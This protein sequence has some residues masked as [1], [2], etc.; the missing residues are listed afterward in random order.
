MAGLKSVYER[1][2]E[3]LETLGHQLSFYLKA[4]AWTPRTIR[5]YKKEIFRIL[6]EVALG[7]GSLAL[8]GGTSP[9]SAA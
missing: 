7:T 9:S 6:A 2:V 4:L 1:P 8:I 5:R 3:G